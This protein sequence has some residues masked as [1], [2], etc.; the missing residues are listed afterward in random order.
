MIVSIRKYFRSKIKRHYQDTLIERLNGEH[1]KLFAI[2]G[3]M[4]EAIEA[5][6]LK[7]IKKLVDKFKTELV[8]HLLYEDTNLYEHLYNRYYYYKNVRDEIKKKHN[9]MKDIAGAVQ[10]FIEKHK[11]LDDLD[12]FKKDFDGVK[13]VLVKRVSFEEEILYDIYH[14][15]QKNDVIINKLKN[16]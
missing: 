10:K 3:K 14:T 6:N 16:S 7:K 5:K 11:N 13:G 8:L 9:E 15:M 2:V 1:Q 12:D 4:D